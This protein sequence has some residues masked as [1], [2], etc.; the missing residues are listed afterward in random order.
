MKKSRGKNS[1][2][3]HL[4]V[5]AD[6][7]ENAARHPGAQHSSQLWEL[8]SNPA[9]WRGMRVKKGRQYPV[10]QDPRQNSL[11]S[12]GTHRD[13]EPQCILHWGTDDCPFVWWNDLQLPEKN[14]EDVLMKRLRQSWWWIWDEGIRYEGK[15]HACNVCT[16]T[17]FYVLPNLFLKYNGPQIAK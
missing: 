1:K 9:G 2:S 14:Q 5:S 17:R 13:M 12:E 11:R 7:S 16:R 10:G 6:P 3:R 8:Q 4:V 15:S